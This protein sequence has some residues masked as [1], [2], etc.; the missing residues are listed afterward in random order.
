MIVPKSLA[1][2]VSPYLLESTLSL[3]ED[4]DGHMCYSPDAIDASLANQAALA[5]GM[6]WGKSVENERILTHILKTYRGKLVI[7]A[8][9]K[10]KSCVTITSLVDLVS[11]VPV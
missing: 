11:A 2:A 1:T 7:D 5:I 10:I 9:G 4:R 6:G 8:D 3:I